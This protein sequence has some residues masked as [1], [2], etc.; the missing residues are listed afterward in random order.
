[1]TNNRWDINN[2]T[3]RRKAWWSS[4]FFND[5]NFTNYF[6]LNLHEIAPGVF[7][8]SQPTMGQF[9]MLKEKYG[10]KTIILTIID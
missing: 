3:E 7:R 10:I 6:R 4:M 2:P 9:K 8:S 5:H 1:M